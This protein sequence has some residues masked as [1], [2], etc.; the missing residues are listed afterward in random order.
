MENFEYKYVAYCDILGFSNA[1]INNFDKTIS[2]YREFK[3]VIIGRSDMF[4]VEVLI[5]SDSIMIVGEKLMTVAQATQLLI[6]WT[7]SQ[8]EWLIRGGIAYG[9]HWKEHDGNN[10]LIV[11]EALVKAVNIEKTIRNPI[12]L[13]SE[14][15]S[16]GLEYWIHGFGNSVFDLPIIH[17]NN[18]NIINPFNKAWFRS[19][20]IILCYLKETYPE[21]I[22]KYEYLLELIE[23]VKRNEC[24]IPAVI[25][26]DLLEKKLIQKK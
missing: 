17:Y 25:I 23:A 19:A 16:L 11:S 12:V 21:Y 15:I 10:T 26:N 24:F 22:T 1:V 6:L 8:K 3:N 5:V 7:C 9:K 2:V 18:N 20:E 13:I 4:D 14:E